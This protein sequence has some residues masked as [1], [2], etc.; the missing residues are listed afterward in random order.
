MLKCHWVAIL[1]LFSAELL[2]KKYFFVDSKRKLGWV[3]SSRRSN[4]ISFVLVSY[5]I[6]RN[7]FE[8]EVRP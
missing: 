6:E 8:N 3:I 4:L 5:G 7:K 2:S 1:G